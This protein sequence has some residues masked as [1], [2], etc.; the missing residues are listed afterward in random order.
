MSTWTGPWRVVTADKVHV[1]SVQNI[2]TGKVKD[3][4]V[5]RH[6]FYA[7]KDLDMTAALKQLSPHTLVQVEFEMARIVDISEVKDGQDFDVCDKLIIN[8][9]N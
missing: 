1:N 4:H 3:V 7:D 2:V 9:S 5:V 6:G 8:Q